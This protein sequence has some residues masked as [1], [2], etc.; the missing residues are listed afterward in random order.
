MPANA[1]IT[2]FYTFAANTKARATYV[3]TNFSNF[4]GH[5]IAIDP[6]TAT[7]ATTETYDLGSTEYRWRTGYFRDIDLKSNTTTGQALQIIGD[8]AAGNGAFNFRIG[9]TLAAQL[10]TY[11]FKGAPPSFTTTAAAGQWLSYFHNTA[12]AV[13][14]AATGSTEYILYGTT[15]TITTVGRPVEVIFGIGN[16]TTS[17]FRHE[18]ATVGTYVIGE[19]RAKLYRNGTMV[20]YLHLGWD[21]K[22]NTLSASQ[23]NIP[24]LLFRD[25]SAPAG[26]NQYSISIFKEVTG[27]QIAYNYCHLYIREY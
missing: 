24:K 7:A 23:F 15:A 20:E 17:A 26:N 27:T 4:R 18:T 2:S 22:A 21:N 11:G 12:T 25:T 14:T 9:S 6:N 1:T 16:T 13:G 10:T 5:L 8:T 3:N 19:V